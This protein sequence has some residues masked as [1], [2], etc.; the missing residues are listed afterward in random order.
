MR[1][2]GGISGIRA[3]DFDAL[4]AEAVR[5]IASRHPDAAS[6][7]QDADLSGVGRYYDEIVS[8]YLEDWERYRA[9]VRGYTRASLAAFERARR[10]NL[11]VGSPSSERLVKGGRRG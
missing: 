6:Y 1:A 7:V 10:S 4:M 11:L 9:A 5:Y 2:S 3:E 8:V